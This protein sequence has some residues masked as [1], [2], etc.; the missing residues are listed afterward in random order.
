MRG[1][2]FERLVIELNGFPFHPQ[3]DHHPFLPGVIVL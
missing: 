3:F 1:S 2:R